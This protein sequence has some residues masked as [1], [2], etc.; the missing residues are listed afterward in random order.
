MSAGG[1]H[2]FFNR[3]VITDEDIRFWL[4]ERVMPPDRLN[5]RWV[6]DQLGLE[7]YDAWKKISK[8]DKKAAVCEEN[9]FNGYEKWQKAFIAASINKLCNDGGI[10]N[11]EWVFRR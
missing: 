1:F 3:E 9:A 8:N 6:L 2:H 10:E 11:P 4:G 5:V 7:E